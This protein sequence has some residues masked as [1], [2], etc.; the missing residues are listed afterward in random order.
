MRSTR[1]SKVLR[2]HT[3]GTGHSRPPDLVLALAEFEFHGTS[4]RSL[5]RWYPDESRVR[6]ALLDWLLASRLAA[7]GLRAETL[8][9]LDSD[10]EIVGEQLTIRLII[11]AQRSGTSTGRGQKIVGD[12]G[13]LYQM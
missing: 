12:T 7:N 13:R 9:R 6:K 2:L 8:P 5:A 3:R 1:R 11:T 4:L 10:D